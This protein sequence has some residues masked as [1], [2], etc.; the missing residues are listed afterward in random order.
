[1]S[2][3]IDN[4]STHTPTDIAAYLNPYPKT[5]FRELSQ[6]E[7]EEW[8][9]G[10]GTAVGAKYGNMKKATIVVKGIYA[11]DPTHIVGGLPAP[12]TDDLEYVR[13]VRD[14]CMPIIKRLDS[15]PSP[16]AIAH[17]LRDERIL[18][19]NTD[20]RDCPLANYFTA[21]TQHDVEVHTDC[22]AVTRSFER[23]LTSQ[24]GAKM[25]EIREMRIVVSQ[26]PEKLQKFVSRFDGGKYH[27][28]Y[29]V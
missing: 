2:S 10:F 8:T 27:Y 19:K 18:G 5:E 21:M 29:R 9:S 20:P 4:I 16:K 13:T 12:T 25:T 28:L 15:L 7:V 6:D 3:G 17:F 22:L 26:L 11:A 1:M 24:H 14:L 23:S